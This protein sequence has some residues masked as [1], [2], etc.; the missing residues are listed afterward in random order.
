MQEEQLCC[1]GREAGRA[2]VFLCW[3][4]VGS[5]C[6]RLRYE[7]ELRRGGDDRQGGGRLQGSDVEFAM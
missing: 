5:R 7:E 1:G 4:L 6:M 2:E 3:G